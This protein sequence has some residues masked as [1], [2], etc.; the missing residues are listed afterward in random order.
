MKQPKI[1]LDLTPITE[2]KLEELGFEKVLE[3]CFTIDGKEYMLVTD[4]NKNL[5]FLL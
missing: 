2:A 3:I 4:E 1:E 5:K